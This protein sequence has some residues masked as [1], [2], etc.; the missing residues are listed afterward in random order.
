MSQR[1]YEGKT[2]KWPAIVIGLAVAVIVVAPAQADAAPYLTKG[3]AC[4]QAGKRIHRGW[5]GVVPGSGHCDIQR[6]P[7]RT[8]IVMASMSYRTYRAGRWMTTVMVRKTWSGYRTRILV[9]SRL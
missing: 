5:V 2:R 1:N 8:N 6:H 4:S 7:T 3:Q 9:D